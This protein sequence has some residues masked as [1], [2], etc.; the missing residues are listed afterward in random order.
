MK[1]LSDMCRHILRHHLWLTMFL[2]LYL[3]AGSYVSFGNFH[4]IDLPWIAGI[5][6]QAR[7]DAG[8]SPLKFISFLFMLCPIFCLFLEFKVLNRIPA[9]SRFIKIYW[10]NIGL[11]W[12]TLWCVFYWRQDPERVTGE[13]SIFIPLFLLTWLSTNLFLAGLMVVKSKPRI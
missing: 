10:R 7:F 2:F 11:S 1:A 5:D 3:V 6:Y 8:A 12:V 9:A 13:N 4:H